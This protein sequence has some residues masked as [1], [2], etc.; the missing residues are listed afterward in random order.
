MTILTLSQK[1]AI[2][3]AQGGKRTVKRY[4]K[5][6]MRQLAKLGAHVMHSLYRRE[7]VLLN[8]F[9]IVDRRTG[10]AVS[11]LSG[12][13]LDDVQLPTFAPDPEFDELVF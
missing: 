12:R 4:G 7:P 13:S 10:K 6:Y 11:L 5:Q 3:G 9:A 2:A 8:D 1:R